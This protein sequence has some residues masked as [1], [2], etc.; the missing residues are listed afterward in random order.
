MRFRQGAARWWICDANLLWRVGASASR[1]L[2]ARRWRRTDGQNEVKCGSD[3]KVCSQ[4][5]Q[6][7]HDGSTR[8]CEARRRQLKFRPSPS[9]VG[10]PIA[11]SGPS[12]FPA[13]PTLVPSLDQK[14]AHSNS[15]ISFH[16]LGTQRLGRMFQTMSGFKLART[17][18]S[19][20]ARSCIGASYQFLSNEMSAFDWHGIGRRSWRRGGIF[21]CIIGDERCVCRRLELTWT[22]ERVARDVCR[23]RSS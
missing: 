20:Y 22:E 14:D 21:P 12:H 3:C 10:P 7:T 5:R 4:Q 17:Q 6:V 18:T 16:S 19:H 9:S 2:N 15:T 8:K 23:Y 13:I 1:I 11:G